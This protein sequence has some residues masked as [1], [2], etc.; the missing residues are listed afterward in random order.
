MSH[1]ATHVATDAST[2]AVPLWLLEGFA[3]YVALRDVDLPRRALGVPDHRRGA[4]R[5]PAGGACPARPS[6]APA[7][8]TSAR[9]TRAP[10]WPRR[11]LARDGGE[12][13]LVRFYDGRRRRHAAGPGA[14]SRSSGCRSEAFTERWRALLRDL[15]G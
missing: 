2:S 3:D 5:R 14:A 8:P 9:R 15:A 12:D 11:L 7:R 6:S 13:D 10:G 4:S 1:E